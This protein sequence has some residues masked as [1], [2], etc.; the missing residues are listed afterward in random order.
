MPSFGLENVRAPASS[1]TAA[2]GTESDADRPPSP[3]ACA[4]QA[5]DSKHDDD[6]L[7]RQILL[8]ELLRQAG[9]YNDARGVLNE[10]PRE[11]LE[12]YVEKYPVLKG[13]L[14][15]LRRRIENGEKEPISPPRS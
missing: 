15:E 14:A 2:R 5:A 10:T 4:W 3:P 8:A 13:M 6:W 12:G 11:P 1:A 7:Y 9:D